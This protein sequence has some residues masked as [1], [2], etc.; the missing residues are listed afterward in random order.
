MKNLKLG[1]KFAEILKNPAIAK[2]TGAALI[3]GLLAVAPVAEVANAE[4]NTT[5]TQVTQSGNE[6]TAGD[7]LAA[8][9]AGG[10]SQEAELPERQ[11]YEMTLE[12]FENGA[13]NAY[14]ELSKYINYEHMVEDVL[15]S[16]YIT[17]YEYISE[18]LEEQ[19]IE[20]GYIA[21]TDMFDPDGIP[22][23]DRSG[24]KNINYYNR[25]VNS[26]NDYNEDRIQ[27]E[28]YDVKNKTGV[29]SPMEAYI[30]ASV[31]CAEEYDRQDMHELFEKWYNEYDLTAGTIRNN[32]AFEQAHKH[33][34]HLNSGEGQSQLYEASMGARYTELKVYGN[35]VMDF[36]TDYMEENYSYDELD[37]YFKPEELRQGSQF[38]LRDDFENQTE[39]P[40]E[41][42]FCVR[43]FGEHWHF[44]RDEVNKELFT[45][46]QTREL[47]RDAQ[48]K[49][50]SK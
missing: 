8:L 36:Q 44:V 33:L 10:Q 4:S 5:D 28:Y 32:E 18:E 30:D 6:L 38:F 29:K 49:G 16:Y 19:L 39:C 41:L 22:Q 40:D 25:L 45:V 37:E 23:M 14:N 31:L 11:H 2:K 43:W 27:R 20:K 9:L 48:E 15:A 34:T 7:S 47:A 24:W 50:L 26:I 1:D 3:A 46:M 21:D 12:E 35:E 17:N 42:Y 13:L